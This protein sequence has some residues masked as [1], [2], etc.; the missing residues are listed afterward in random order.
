[1][2]GK[3]VEDN[4]PR[5]ALCAS[6]LVVF[7]ERIASVLEKRDPVLGAHIVEPCGEYRRRR[8]GYF[9]KSVTAWLNIP[10]LSDGLFGSLVE[11]VG[12]EFHRRRMVIRMESKSSTTIPTIQ[13]RLAPPNR[14][15]IAR[16]IAMPWQIRAKSFSL[17]QRLL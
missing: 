6:L 15:E 5:L 1:M 4:P 11:L 16:P 3:V 9:E 2:C 14:A 10:V 8:L 17:I 12:T 13:A 7:D